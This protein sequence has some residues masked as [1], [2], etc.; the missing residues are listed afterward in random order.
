MLISWNIKTNIC[1][2]YFCNYIHL[3]AVN[4]GKWKRK[5]KKDKRLQKEK[6]KQFN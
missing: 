4:M 3:E 1:G 2:S 6:Q 5:E